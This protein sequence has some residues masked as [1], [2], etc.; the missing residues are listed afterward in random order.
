MPSKFLW[1]IPIPLIA[2]NG[3]PPLRRSGRIATNPFSSLKVALLAIIIFMVSTPI[4]A[5]ASLVINE[6]DYDNFSTPDRAEFIEIK[7]VSG[8]DID[9]STTPY[10]LD[11]INGSDGTSYTTIN[12]NSGTIADGDYFVICANNA[13]VANCDKDVLPDTDL[14]ENDVEAVVLKNGNLIVDTVSYE[15]GVTNYVETTA[16]STADDGEYFLGLSR[17]PDGQ[18]TNNNSADFQL[19]CVTP[20][21]ANNMTASNDCYRLYLSEASITEGDSGT[22]TLDVTVNLTQ[23]PNS[24]VTV[25][26]RTEDIMSATV[27]EDYV[28]IGLTQLTFPAFDNTPQTISVIINGDEIDEG[29]DEGFKVRL[30]EQSNNAQ[31]TT[32]GYEIYATITDDDNAGFMVNP[33]NLI[34]S[35]P[36]TSKT[37]S[38]KLNS[39]PTDDVIVNLREELGVLECTTNKTSFT[40]TP[41]NWN[42]EQTV[43]ITAEDDNI[44]DGTRNCDIEFDSFQINTTDANYSN[45]VPSNITIQVED[46]ESPGGSITESG[47]NTQVGEEGLTTD[48]YDFVLRQPPIAD[49]TV[50][51]S[52][53]FST[54]FQCEITSSQQLTFTSGDWNTPQTVTVQATQDY[55]AETAIHDCIIGHNFSASADTTYSSLPTKK[56]TVAVVDDDK[57]AIIVDN[58]LPPGPE[59][60]A[61][62]EPDSMNSFTINLTSEPA[63]GAEVTIGLSTSNSQCSVPSSVTIGNIDW[64]FGGQSVTV[65]AIDDSITDGDQICI[66]QT[67]SA[68]SDDPNYNGIDPDDLTVTVM[69]DDIPGVNVS[70]SVV[71]ITE[72]TSDNYNIGL[73]TNP[74]GN[75]TIGITSAD[76]SQCT[77]S[78]SSV[79]VNNTNNKEITITVVD[80]PEFEGEHSC[81]INHTITASA[82]SNYPTTM[83]VNSKTANITDNEHGVLFTQ[84]N[85]STDVTE[86]STTDTIEVKLSTQPTANVTVTITPNSQVDLGE[87]AGT[88]KTLTFTNA[89]WNTAKI[90]TVTANNDSE[91]EG[92]HTGTITYNAGSTDTHYN[93]ADGV[94]KYIVDDAEASS[95]TVNITDNDVAPPIPPTPTPVPTTTP[96]PAPTGPAISIT[97]AGPV[98]QFA[99]DG[100]G[101]VT[102]SENSSSKFSCHSSKTCPTQIPTGWY[103]FEP[104]ADQGS[105]FVEWRGQNCKNGEYTTTFGGTCIAV[106][107]LVIPPQNSVNVTLSPDTPT[108]PDTTL[109]SCPDTTR[110]YVN[111]AAIGGDTGCNWLNAAINL[112]TA[113][114][115]IGTIYPSVKE[116]WIAKGTYYPSTDGN[117]NASFQLLN[118]VS[119]YGGFAGS[120]TELKQ[121][122]SATNPTIFSGDIGKQKDN[123][124]NSYNVVNGSN[125]N[126]T[127]LLKGVTIEAGNANGDTCPQ[128]CGGGVYNNNGSPTLKHIFVRNNAAVY[129]GGLYNGN[130]SQP[131]VKESMIDNNSATDGGGMFNDNSSPTLSHVFITGNTASHQGGGMLN[132]NQA[133]PIMGHVNLAGNS[134]T[135][136][137]G[138]LN[139]NSSLV[140]SHSIVR[141]NEADNGAGVVN[142]NQSTPLISHVIISGNVAT[143]TGGAMLN[144]SS[145]PILSQSTISGN[146]APKNSGIRN[147]TGSQT[148]INNSILWANILTN[149]NNSTLLVNIHNF[150]ATSAIQLED[151]SGSVTTVNNSI[152]QGG[153]TGNGSNNLA[154]DP[155]FTEPV[156]DNITT[157]TTMGDFHLQADSPAINAGDNKLLPQDFTDAECTN[158]FGDGNTTE[159]VDVDF[160]GRTR[161]IGEVVDMGVYEVQTLPE[162]QIPAT[163]KYTL[164][165]TLTGEGQGSVA[166]NKDGITCGNDCSQDYL[167]GTAINL[168]TRTE[169]G[170]IFGGWEGDCSGDKGDFMVVMDAAKQCTAKFDIAPVEKP[171]VKML[172]ESATPTTV[173]SGPSS[174]GS[175]ACNSSSGTINQSCNAGD[176]T[177]TDFGV[178]EVGKSA[179]IANVVLDTLLVNNGRLSNITVAPE[180][181]ITGGIVTGNAK[182]E[183]RM[184]DFEFV[185]ATLSGVNDAGE[186][187]GTIAGEVSNNSQVGGS[188]EEVRLAPETHITGGILAKRIIGDSDKSAILERLHIKTN[189]VVSNVILAEDVTYGE[190]VIFTNVEFRTKVV[191]KI[192]LQ[193][194]ING[195]RFQETFTRIESVT[196]RANSHLAN[197]DIGDN[198]VFENGVTLDDN[199]TFSVHQR[200]METHSI[201]V[202]PNLNGL[203]AID[204]Q[205]NTISTWAKLQSGVRFGADDEGYQKKVT[206][207]RSKR[208]NVDI[209]GNVL[210]DVRHIGL[211]AD[212]LV[213]AAY[214]PP[215]ASSPSFYMLDSDGTPLPWDM[216]MSS[217]VPFRAKVKLTPVVPVPIWNN[218][219]DII[220]N[221]QVYFGY[222]LVK[223]KALVY[224]LE[225]VIGMTFTESIH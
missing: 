48:T 184:E 178:S 164:T 148:F 40:F 61:V 98:V 62:T 6:I 91:T 112:Q 109:P 97:P 131:L 46:D 124:D 47:G 187:V 38:I 22:K 89:N 225:D 80:D 3:L 143:E 36:N 42:A 113:L 195:T 21:T 198:V 191:R 135:L 151:D 95:I 136:G 172:D 119:I 141:E 170:S 54:E 32:V 17:Y 128:A 110:L 78:P 66:V 7:N 206:F 37:F 145:S 189:S 173:T 106:F 202:L 205:G 126:A 105:E 10:T 71:N 85:T 152:V 174:I 203:A 55:T 41:S 171:V 13:N 107:K 87:G 59:P 84:S 51:L 11:F 69:D 30:Y 65:T 103:K 194:R 169:A 167:S 24:A 58:M 18:D 193:G 190:G 79:T 144:R 162:V 35:E 147:E 207:K 221:L 177:I 127:A 213:V 179:Q 34:I 102:A 108:V 212:I 29:A 73:Y 161:I 64:M 216:D 72:G 223:T 156:T 45:Q 197:L 118:G 75:V 185:G 149:I 176:K 186:V 192:N 2:Q 153:W 27:G 122:N 130:N 94:V 182:N 160:E 26:Y 104:S 86:G 139:A 158:G 217:L 49:V 155:L 70:G 93:Q 115:K 132:Q 137:G 114:Q 183:G 5:D 133:E 180:G 157:H 220:G 33:T 201:A 50:D 163:P 165:V 1:G 57:A 111:Q 53:D 224:S 9:F 76:S 43:T 129:G 166:S 210:T 19:K 67:A 117:R 63:N 125:T 99:G 96:S 90:I 199:V 146:M 219:L 81:T 181:Q 140:L 215:G 28:A 200:Y 154:I 4:F 150:N 101:S 116:V 83:S 92:S 218:P 211:K 44:Q 134:A 60:F 8:G 168:I 120:E 15:G 209:L 23:A 214:T 16:I 121:R 196:I 123:S 204:N 159:I 100:S 12:L 56:I 222:R 68:I 88:I 74:T 82:D 142:L 39:E 14:I 175:V 31:I 188:F 20:G 138:I 77:V 52:I 208:K 25:D